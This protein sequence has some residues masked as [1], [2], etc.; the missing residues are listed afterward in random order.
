MEK[1]IAQIRCKKARPY[2][3]EEIKSHIESQVEDNISAGM[4][5]E[6]AEKNAVMDMGDPIEVGIALDRIHKPRVAWTLLAI[7][8]ILSLFGILAQVSI[9][10]Q[11]GFSGLEPFRQE[12]LQLLTEG[13]VSSV[14]L[15]F[16]I[17]SV[18]YF[19]DYTML[20]KYA[21]VI[22]LFIIAMGMLLLGKFFGTDINGIRYSIGFGMF[23]VSASCVM[24]FYVPIYGAILYRYRNG[25][26]SAL[27]KA[28][29]W[30]MIPVLITLRIPCFVV[31]G[32]MMMSM[33]VQ[34]TV[35]IGKGWFQIPVRKTIACLW[36]AF[37][38]LPALLLFIL[39]AFDFLRTYQ[40]DRLRN[41]FMAS[42]EVS[43][44]TSLLRAFGRN[45]V[46]FGN[47]GEDVIG[48]LPEFNRD[49]IFSYILS[50]Y[51]MLAG[52]LLAAVLT[53]LV[54]FIF[55]AVTKQ[56]N[57]LGM[58]MGFGCGMI[59]LLNI[60]INL[61]VV[62]GIIPPV[63][64]FLPFVSIGRDNILLCYALLGMVMSIYRYKD[65]YPRHGIPLLLSAG[66]T[67]R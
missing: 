49:Y 27:L 48:R 38:L 56:K 57:E 34:L 41:F 45:V 55:G 19:I 61:S 29:V 13:F 66:E 43:Y 51:G 16:I 12:T 15:G 63:S 39:C 36:S 17:M 22:G 21:K 7:V 9:L 6:E 20:A 18:M 35:A 24:M 62:L 58:V 14:I 59:F 31:A 5:Q 37:L 3:A 60:L 8:G 42:G 4:T 32:I 65:V 47:S 2:I 64:S 46:M 54:M 33:L 44:V 30:L 25:G 10:H 67:Y 26:I 40:T 53:A 23:R 11:T 52:I 50:S 28:I 1:L